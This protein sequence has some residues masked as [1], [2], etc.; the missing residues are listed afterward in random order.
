[1]LD[2]IDEISC[3]LELMLQRQKKRIEKL[4]EDPQKWGLQGNV[5]WSL[6]LVKRLREAVE[7]LRRGYFSSH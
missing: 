2:A 5:D 1:M 3:Q 4:D 6:R 7:K